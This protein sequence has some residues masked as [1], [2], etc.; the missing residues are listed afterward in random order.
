MDILII[1]SWQVIFERSA[2]EERFR[3][4]ETKWH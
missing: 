1:L 2:D 4:A 3:P